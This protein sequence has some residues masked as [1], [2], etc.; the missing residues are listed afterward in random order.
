[1]DSCFQKREKPIFLALCCKGDQLGCH[2]MFFWAIAGFMQIMPKRNIAGGF[3]LILV[4]KFHK[5]NCQKCISSNGF[6]I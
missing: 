4:I 3:W 2:F 6:F 5:F 1:M